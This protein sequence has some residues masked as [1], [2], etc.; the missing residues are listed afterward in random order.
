MKNTAIAMIASAAVALAPASPLLAD[1]GAAKDTDTIAKAWVP[2]TQA[3]KVEARGGTSNYLSF[4]S[5]TNTFCSNVT[6]K[7]FFCRSYDKEG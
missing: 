4:Y 5:L 7:I 2:A 6:I 3:E 1:A